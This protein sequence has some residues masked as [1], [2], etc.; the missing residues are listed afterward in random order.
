MKLSFSKK[1]TGAALALG[2]S[3]S[4]AAVPMS[5]VG[6]VDTLLGSTFLSDSSLD[7]ENT[8]IQSILGGSYTLT[9]KFEN[10][11]SDTWQSVDGDPDGYALNFAD[12][13]CTTG[14]CT[15]MPTY[16][17]LKLGTGGSPEGTA[18]TYL[19]E[20]LPSMAWA[21]VQLGQFADVLDMNIG[22]VS[23]ISVGNGGRE[24]PEPASLALL[25]LGLLGMGAARRMRKTAKA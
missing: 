6:S 23:H 17:V 10:L 7:S 8:F 13:N 4:A 2:L 20:N 14:S 22:R 5:T 25:G 18:D 11:V 21:Y 19:F 16:F 12:L 9:G 24:V 15:T 3:F 1:L